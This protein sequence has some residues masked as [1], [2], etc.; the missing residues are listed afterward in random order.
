MKT[1][2]LQNIFLSLGVIFGLAITVHAQNLKPMCSSSGPAVEPKH[3]QRSRPNEARN[4]LVIAISDWR[5]RKEKEFCFRQL[6]AIY[7]VLYS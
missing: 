4:D 7:A 1:K 2:I 3:D 6:T 5:L